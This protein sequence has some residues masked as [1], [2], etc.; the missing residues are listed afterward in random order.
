[1]ASTIAE[2]ILPWVILLMARGGM[3]ST[4]KVLR[5]G[6]PVFCLIFASCLVSVLAM[7]RATKPLEPAQ[8]MIGSFTPNVIGLPG[9][10]TS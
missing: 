7:V 1:M 2:S 6:E 9:A 10:I 8:D 4:N 5:S 3:F